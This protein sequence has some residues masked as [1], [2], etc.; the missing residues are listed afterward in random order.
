MARRTILNNTGV[1]PIQRDMKIVNPDGTPT[2]A[3]L[4]NWQRQRAS[5]S[6]SATNIEE[7]IALVNSLAATNITTTAPITGGGLLS[8]PPA[9][10]GLADTAVVPGSYTN[11]DITVD[12]KGRITAAAN[13]TGGGAG[14][15]YFNGAAIDGTVAV[16]A[17]AFAT[18]VLKFTPTTN[19]TISHVWA[20]IDPAAGTDTYYAQIAT[21][22][23]GNVG[24]VLGQTT[25]SAAVGYTD[26]NH[27]RLAFASP[28][29]LTAGTTYLI[30]V[31][32]ANAALGT[33]PLRIGAFAAGVGS[34]SMDA[35]G[36]IPWTAPTYTVATIGLTNG[37]ALGAAGADGGRFVMWLEGQLTSTAKAR[38]WGASLGWPNNIAVNAMATKGSLLQPY[39]DITVDA[40][41]GSV[42]A[43][44]VGNTYV[45]RIYQQSG[46]T[47]TIGTLIATSGVL[48]ATVT[49]PIAF[50]FAFASPVIL[51]S[52]N[53]YLIVFSITSGI[54]TTVA[55]VGEAQI[56]GA[57]AWN[58]NGP[59]YNLPNYYEY[60]AIAPA[61][62]QAPSNT[63]TTRL[64]F[65]IEGSA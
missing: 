17:S 48:A 23:G 16:S 11:A 19:L 14:S 6:G 35:P 30:S 10:I 29:L 24:T 32:Y 58:I 59:G 8:G 40:V 9:A 64:A 33:T 37:Q 31:T 39:A 65:H 22:S 60:N 52:G 61:A 47:G 54:G 50:R 27:I 46:V 62:A 51:T 7:A 57:N 49:E 42:D 45:C 41:W 44:A 2:Q 5:N 13:G 56:T 18:K 1:D 53:T 20:W 15:S 25:T 12:A 28:I 4:R 26:Q 34:L 38:I 21:Q 3:F 63:F 43:A 36:T 55:R